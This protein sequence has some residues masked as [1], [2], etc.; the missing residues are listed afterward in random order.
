MA[1]MTLL[2]DYGNTCAQINRRRN[3]PPCHEICFKDNNSIM[4]TI[5]IYPRSYPGKVPAVPMG[6]FSSV[7]ER[8]TR[9][10]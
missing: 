3:E 7:V 4:F 9:A 10:G 8:E 6:S 2:M 5:A 1:C